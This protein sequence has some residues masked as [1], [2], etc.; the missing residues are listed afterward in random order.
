MNAL[1][2]STLVLVC[3]MASGHAATSS[4]AFNGS[5]NLAF[6][7][8][9]GTCDPTYNFTVNVSNGLVT[10]PKL[11]KFRGY[12]QSSGS[13][14]CQWPNGRMAGASH[15]RRGSCL[16]VLQLYTPEQIDGQS[17]DNVV[18]SSHASPHDRCS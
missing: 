6:V 15:F 12:L 10:H 2:L 8:Q 13:I 4:A 18:A 7:T 1:P 3:C 17:I 16:P 5:W 9:S 11:V 14:P